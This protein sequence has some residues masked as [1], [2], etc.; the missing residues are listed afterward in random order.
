MT[1]RDSAADVSPYGTLMFNKCDHGQFTV[2]ASGRHTTPSFRPR[3]AAAVGTKNGTE[4][5]LAVS[6]LPSTVC[7]M[8]LKPARSFRWFCAHQPGQHHG[9]PD[10]VHG[11]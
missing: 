6:R 11:T 9:H 1:V 5:T 3:I 10:G 4:S 2:A 8:Q 7:L